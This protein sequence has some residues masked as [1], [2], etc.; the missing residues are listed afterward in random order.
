[1]VQYTAV[2]KKFDSMG[3]K[4]GWTYIDV[5]A[6]IAQQLKKDTKKSFRVKGRLDEYE[7]YGLALTPMGG[8]DYIL[9]L[10]AAIRKQIKKQK[11][12]MLCV[13]IEADDR[14]ILPPADLLDC[15]TDEPAALAH[16]NTI[17][18]S[19]QLYFI[20]YIE[21]AKTDATRTKR[22]AQSV[23]TLSKKLGF[24]DMLR[25]LKNDKIHIAK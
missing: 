24:S 13:Q 9:A 14:P 3:E 25:S 17:A 16:F 20:R 4:T 2:I 6:A 10:K 1:M 19:H 22:I 23:N 7:F 15:L 12:D 8:G 18:P 5:P 11:G 21:S